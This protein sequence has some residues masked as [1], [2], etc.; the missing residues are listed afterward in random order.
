MAKFTALLLFLLAFTAGVLAQNPEDLGSRFFRVTV[1]M[2]EKP[3]LAS[4]IFE[5]TAGNLIVKGAPLATVIGRAYGVET[6]AVVDAPGWVHEDHLYDI[7][8]APPP[9]ALV[10][11]DASAMLRA[12]LADRFNLQIRQETREVTM[13]V[14]DV[15]RAKQTELAL[16]AEERRNSGLVLTPPPPPPE[17]RAPTVEEIE[18]ASA[19]FQSLRYTPV[20]TKAL[21]N[22]FSRRIGEPIVDLT[23][24]AAV[25]VLSMPV[26]LPEPEEDPLGSS[27]EQL[28]QWGLILERRTVP[29]E[30]IAITAIERPIVD[31]VDR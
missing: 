12:L 2:N 17:G 9:V 3:L 25:H 4:A 27:S 22:A 18:R 29:L 23:G 14:L 28:A 21:L 16:E 15:D 10:Q 8:A 30:V 20:A 19:Y 1:T 24:M 5:D 13:L 31:A 11:A 6:S 26:V 7:E